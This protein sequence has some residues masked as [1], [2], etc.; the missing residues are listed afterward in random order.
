MNDVLRLFAVE[1]VSTASVAAFAADHD[2]A[3]VYKRPWTST[4]V[5]SLWADDGRQLALSAHAESGVGVFSVRAADTA[6]VDAL[7]A[8]FEVL[9]SDELLARAGAASDPVATLRSIYLLSSLLDSDA[10]GHA[11]AYDL[12]EQHLV[13]DRDLIRWAAARVLSIRTNARAVDAL[14]QAASRFPDLSGEYERASELFESANDGTLYDDH[15][16]S[17]AELIRRA[18]QGLEDNQYK[19][20]EKAAEMLLD[21]AAYHAEGLLLRALAYEAL[22]EP[23]LALALA[24]ASLEEQRCSGDDDDELRAETEEAIARLSTVVGTVEPDERFDSE[25]SRWNAKFADAYHRAASA[26]MANVLR[27]HVPVREALFA[28]AS[29]RY[30]GDVALL[31]RAVELAPTSVPC[32]AS[33]AEN[34]PDERAE[35][36]MRLYEQALEYCDVAPDSVAAM[37]QEYADRPDPI[38]RESIIEGLARSYYDAKAWDEAA[39]WADRLVDEAPRSTTGWQMRANART[40]ALRHEEAVEAYEDAIREL[41]ALLDDPDSFYFGDDPMGGMHFNHSCVLAKLGRR[42]EALDALRRAARI[43]LVWAERAREDDYWETYWEDDEFAAVCEGS[44]FATAAELDRDHVEDLVIQALGRSYRGDLEE[45]VDAATWAAELAHTAGFRDLEVRALT[46]Y[47]RTI[48]FHE[49]P[50]FGLDLMKQAYD[51]AHEHPAEVGDMLVADTTHDYAVVLHAA[52]HFDDADETYLRA[53][54][55]RRAAYGS[56]HPILAKSFGDMARLRFTLGDEDAGV[57]LLD[58]GLELL[59]TYFSAAPH[60]DDDAHGDALVDRASL[61]CKRANL[62]LLLDD[63]QAITYLR[64]TV[65]ALEALMALRY[66]AWNVYDQTYEL[67]QNVTR[68]PSSD[69]ELGQAQELKARLDDLELSDDPDIRAEQSFWRDLRGFCKRMMAQGVSGDVLANTFS[70]AMRG[71][72]LPELLRQSPEIGGLSKAFAQRANRF[73]TFIVSAALALN[74]AEES[75][76]IDQALADLEGICVASVREVVD[77]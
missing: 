25:I 9:D 1:P 3:R 11:D 42:E 18:R 67:V 47:A 52:E 77:G 61:C 57:A 35:E 38:T 75:G 33:L 6:L 43:D 15:T 49:D 17:W 65:D 23:P 50:L 54:D 10:P 41:T 5:D 27:A 45:V 60:V 73:P 36:A 14:E 30:H 71:E 2:L 56:E 16:D 63:E 39:T 20:T 59:S 12:L 48:T 44:S 62:A 46:I 72:E 51:L 32:L 76:E 68:Q 28:F 37:I 7:R 66:T 40:F 53:L 74:M 69:E 13:D 4:F 70:R 31:E 29:G 34:L 21:D 64:H 8:R 26:G 24:G 22:G 55:A 19:R 58:E